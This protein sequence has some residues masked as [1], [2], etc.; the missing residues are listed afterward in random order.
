LYLGKPKQQGDT[1][2]DGQ[3]IWRKGLIVCLFYSK[4]SL[5]TY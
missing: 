3:R 2:P 5:F 1:R 4:R